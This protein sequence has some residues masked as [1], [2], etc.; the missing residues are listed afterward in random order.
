MLYCLFL[1]NKI[2]AKNNY[3]VSVMAIVSEHM[4]QNSI[5]NR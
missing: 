4:Y 1:K 2:I 3:T 5:E